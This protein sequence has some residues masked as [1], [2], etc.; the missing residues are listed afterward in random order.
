MSDGF[1]ERR[2]EN[3]EILGAL[4]GPSAFEVVAKQAPGEIVDHLV[5][6]WD[7]WAGGLS[8][9]DDVTFVV[10]KC[11]DTAKGQETGEGVP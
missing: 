10:V 3:Q 2:N 6:S 11:D 7:D 4:R 8:Q 1:S 9:D 5:K